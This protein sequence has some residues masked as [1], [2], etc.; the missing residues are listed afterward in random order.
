MVKIFD[1]RIEKSE[2]MIDFFN[3]LSTSVIMIML[4]GIGYIMGRLGWMKE[5]EKKFLSKF[6]LNVAVPCVCITG[7]L[8]S[9]DRSMF[10]ELGIMLLVALLTMGIVLIL[11]TI[12]G[13]LLH[14]PRKQKGVFISMCAFPNTIF[15]GLPVSKQLFGEE[16]VPYVMIC[17]IAST[18]MV[19]FIGILLMEHAGGTNKKSSIKEIVKNV[20]TKAPVIGVIVA[21]ILL[22]ADAR[23]PEFT[24]TFMGYI[25]DTVTP[26]ALIFCGYILYEIGLKN[27]RI[28]KGIPFMLILRLVVAP[29]I[30]LG[31]GILM[32]IEVF[33]RSVLLI[34][35]ALPVITQVSVMSGEYGADEQYAVSGSAI[36]IFVGLLTIPIWMIILG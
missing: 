19:Q 13:N 25:R 1:I 11:G 36:S 10:A 31:I 27:L 23:P 3:A 9:L 5:S 22:I 4:M 15:I 24:M 6:I 8:N 35:N 16:C 14:L 28:Q 20:F 7:I 12:V 33:P 17:Y 26:L 21:L 2:K 32:K 18:I 29:V 30:C 34:E